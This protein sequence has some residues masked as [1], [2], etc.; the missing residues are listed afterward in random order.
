MG[1]GGWGKQQL[2]INNVGAEREGG[3]RGRIDREQKEKEDRQ[4]AE[5]DRG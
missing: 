1:G 2:F 4:V 5:R 3:Q